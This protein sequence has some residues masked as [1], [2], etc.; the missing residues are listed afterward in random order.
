[1]TDPLSEDW[2]C[3]RCIDNKLG[4][5]RK[6]AP[7]SI[8]KSI[9]KKPNVDRIKHYDVVEQA[10]AEATAKDDEVKKKLLEKN[11]KTRAKSK[12][13]QKQETL[14]IRTADTKRLE[15]STPSPGTPK[16]WTAEL[17]KA[18]AEGLEV[19]ETYG[20]RSVAFAKAA[21]LTAN[22]ATTNTATT[23]NDG[24]L[25][26][27]DAAS[28][29]T[30]KKSKGSWTKEEKDHLIECVTASHQAGHRGE[31]LWNEVYPNVVARGVNRPL[32]GMRMIWL[33]ELRQ[34][35]GLDERRRQ[36]ASK[37][38]T[39]VQKRKKIEVVEATRRDAEMEDQ[40][41]DE[42]E[43]TEEDDDD[44]VEDT[45][46]IEE[47]EVEETFA[48]AALVMMPKKPV[49]YCARGKSV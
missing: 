29:P 40:T 42:V 28:E 5:L 38:R 27:S 31:D 25:E 1:M 30:A 20:L 16:P 46:D 17:D 18:F 35:I 4:K 45:E 48:T 13:K 9:V 11:E 37:M 22:T 24:D 21:L 23:S 2:F 49:T 14:V 12:E 33:R 10:A 26:M 34:Q 15:T 3:K 43:D 8:S 19:A 6:N 32:G 39:A 44:E 7:K 36:N 41:E 47:V